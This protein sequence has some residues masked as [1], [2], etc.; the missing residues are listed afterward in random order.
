MVDYDIYGFGVVSSW[1]ITDTST[2][3]R[4]GAMMN[5]MN[6]DYMQ[7]GLFMNGWTHEAC[8]SISEGAACT[9]NIKWTLRPSKTLHTLTCG[10]EAMIHQEHIHH[11][12]ELH[13]NMHTNNNMNIPI[14]L[15]RVMSWVISATSLL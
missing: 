10:G 6:K 1:V 3:M 2:W 9:W 15:C 4:D 12:V 7:G 11:S 8:Q 5:D 13:L 14:L